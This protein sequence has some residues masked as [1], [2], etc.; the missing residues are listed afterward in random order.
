MPQTVILRGL[1]QRALA[2]ALIN[3]APVDAV[4]T[5]SEAKRSLPQNARMWAALSDISRARPE[6]RLWTPEQWKGAFMH[7]LGHEV[8]FQQGLDGRGFFPV[9]FSTSRLTKRQFAELITL[10]Q[11]YGD[12]HG[13]AWSEPHPDERASA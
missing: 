13:V 11:E 12:R 6:G 10:I 7:A 3:R 1:E 4:V 9:G 5:I 2:C 8:Q